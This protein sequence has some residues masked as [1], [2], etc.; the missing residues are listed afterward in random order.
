LEGLA[1]FDRL[2]ALLRPGIIATV[3]AVVAITATGSAVAAS[4]I[5]GKDVKNGS[6]TGKDVRNGSLGAKELSKKARNSLRGQK[7]AKGDT[8]AAGAKGDKGDKG[9]PGSSSE[10][11]IKSLPSGGFSATNSSV[12]VT[13]AGAK[14]GPYANGGLAGGSVCYDGFNGRTLSDVS[15]L[16]YRASYSTDDENTVGVPYLRIFLED[17]AH[18]VIFSPNTQPIPAI[19]EDVE[20]EWV[21]NDGT[22]RYD[23][24]AG[25][26]SDE[27]WLDVKA[28]HADEEISAICVSTGFS[29]GTN[30]SAL[31]RSVDLNGSRVV[32][33]G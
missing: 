16:I 10:T 20:Q 18:D 29:G 22:V 30:L 6:L 8:G 2:R 15:T 14:F 3:A 26:N 9:E 32:F 12:T 21:V 13:P 24:D 19:A 7:G 25:N 27:P 11:R 31:L 1:L 28:A 17:D 33:G 4:L 5:T 23:D